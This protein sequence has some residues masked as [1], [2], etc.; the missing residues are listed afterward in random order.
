MS[1]LTGNCGRLIMFAE[2]GD[3]VI[4]QSRC[5][6]HVVEFSLVPHAEMVLRQ[7]H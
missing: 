4:E 1:E 5:C 2:F 3:E 6:K 7:S